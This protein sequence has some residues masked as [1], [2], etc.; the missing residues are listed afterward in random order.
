MEH[1]E[2][3]EKKDDVKVSVIIPIY[4]TG[5]YLKECLDSAISQSLKEIEVICVNDGSTDDTEDILR[6]Y[7]KIDAR[8][9]VY[10]Q[11]NLGVSVAR[12]NA[13]K[14]AT[15]E[16]I[17]FLDSD[18][19]LE[20]DVLCEL[21]NI[22]KERK[23]EVLYF[24]GTSF[25]NHNECQELAER[26][27]NYYTRKNEYPEVTTGPQ[28]MLEMLRNEEYRVTPA[29]Q[30]VQREYLLKNQLSFPV[31]IVQEDN[32]YSY[33]CMLSARQAGYVKMS[34]YKRRVRKDSIM[35]K[36]QA[37]RNSYGY[38]IVHLKMREFLEQ[39]KLSE[40]E[41]KAAAE[42]MYRN[43]QNAKNIFEKLDDEEKKL[44]NHL[45]EQERML[46]KAYIV[47][48]VEMKEKLEEKHG[49]IH[50]GNASRLQEIQQRQDELNDKLQKTYQ[51]K[52]EINAKLQKTYQEK[53]EINAK[54]Q[55]TYQEKY[56]R[57]LEIKKIEEELKQKE[58]Q[59][60]EMSQNPG[61]KLANWLKKF[62]K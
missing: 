45:P 52:S 46:F 62:R 7:E 14:H 53:S 61:I 19:M 43:F 21:Y 56:E 59:I 6:D 8:I 50:A 16:Y 39:Q 36:K 48:A 13:I 4:N 23:L 38:F 1:V 51:E 58:E 60:E 17:Y 5:K 9:C 35:T 42:I 40:E 55:K 34:C 49:V 26:Y 32:Y 47:N 30:L 10:N 31:G 41:E 24:D 44:A 22:A 3:I 12:N 57:G 2:N 33:C 25:S 15:G 27:H 29:L 18:D 28:M 11:K 37:F 20:K 54:L